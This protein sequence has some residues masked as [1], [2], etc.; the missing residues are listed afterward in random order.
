[1]QPREQVA[2]V[3]ESR[4]GVCA[5][6]NGRSAA[7]RHAAYSQSTF[8]HLLRCL[9]GGRIRQIDLVQ[10]AQQFLVRDLLLPQRIQQLAAQATP[11]L[12]QEKA[13]DGGAPTPF[14]Q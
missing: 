7:E 3:A 6:A 12:C 1:M 9:A 4:K 13:R 5:P 2:I 8:Q 10:K 14:V 11:A